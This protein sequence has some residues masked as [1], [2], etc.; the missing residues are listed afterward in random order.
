[1]AKITYGDR[2]GRDGKLGVG[3]SA[4]VLDPANLKVLLVKRSDDRRWAVPGGYMESGETLQEACERE[5]WEETGVRVQATNLVTV[6]SDPNILLEYPDGNK[7]QLVVM[8]FMAR[9]VDGTPARGDETTDAGYF[10]LEETMRMNIGEFDRQRIDDGFAYTG[11]TF[12]KS[13]LGWR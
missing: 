5:V 13:D 12:V 9:L 7:W 4:F 11:T 3:C 6:Y 8:H 10:S 1:M 2:V